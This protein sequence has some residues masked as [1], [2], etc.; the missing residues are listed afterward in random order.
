MA[1]YDRIPG[2]DSEYNLIPEVRRSLAG[3]TEIVNQIGVEIGNDSTIHAAVLQAIED[4][5]AAG[6]VSFNKGSLLNA[7]NLFALPAGTYQVGGTGYSNPNLPEA[8]F[9]ALIIFASN[10]GARSI[11]FVTNDLGDTRN[12]TKTYTIGSDN[13]GSFT[14]KK[15]RE[16]TTNARGVPANHAIDVWAGSTGYNGSFAMT[17]STVESSGSKN[18]TPYGYILDHETQKNGGTRQLA[19]PTHIG[20]Q[21]VYHRA[22]IATASGTL[23]L[24]K[25][26][27]DE[28]MSPALNRHELLYDE[29]ATLYGG[30]I[31]TGGAVPVALTF[32]DYPRDFRDRILPLLVA[33]G[34]SATIG[35]SSKMYDPTSTVIHAGATG[36]TWSEINNWPALISI[37]NHSATHGGAEDRLSI[38]QEIVHGLRDLQS[39]L[40]NK[41]IY[42]FMQP[43]VVYDAGFDNGNTLE[44]YA[45]TIAGHLQLG[46]HAYVTGVRRSPDMATTCL[47]V[48]NR[49]IQGLVR[50]WV[51]SSN[52][53]TTAKRRITAAR[54]KKHGLIVAA[55]ADRFDKVGSAT[56]AEITSFLDWL[57]AEQDA[58]RIRVMKLEEF[59]I[60][61]YGGPGAYV[62]NSVGTR[63]LVHDPGNNKEVLISGDT[64]LRDV[65]SLMD[66]ALYTIPNSGSIRVQRLGRMVT[67]NFSNIAAAVNDSER[68][69]MLQLPV[70]F[71]PW[72]NH[73]FFSYRS[74]TASF[75]TTG[76]L[77]IDGPTT[78]I[79]YGTLTFPTNDP[80]PTTLPG[81]PV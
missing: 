53:I 70:G 11:L 9:G 29:M 16:T 14:G 69:T 10:G 2:M 81:T 71:R 48:G 60:A 63:V 41:P 24:W 22:E 21:G 79:D 12:D 54:A 42:T 17:P 44:S 65:T 13:S 46:H 68:K 30:K 19:Y 64:G 66:T 23:G 40:P 35:L 49:P 38:F 34:L 45:G 72:G 25:R 6:N 61:Q 1:V 26:F 7:D 67:I 52:G 27:V 55:H 8:R 77:K 39:A 28:K 32:D 51:D 50:N 73:Y 43:S 78:S 18:P 58:G 75:V 59:A 57:K 76:E 47:M 36:T 5:L 33:R 56:M 15:W 37:A 80:W 20:D 62:D 74:R 4:A 31:Y 3:S